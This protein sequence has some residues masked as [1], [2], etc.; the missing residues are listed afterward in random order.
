MSLKLERYLSRLQDT[1]LSRRDLEVEELRIADRSD[2]PGRTSEF[3]ARLRFWDGSL[4]EVEEVLT[5]IEGKS[6]V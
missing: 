5:I 6:G 1:I 3:H 2:E 4:L